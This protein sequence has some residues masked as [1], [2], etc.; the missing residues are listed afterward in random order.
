MTVRRARGVLAAAAIAYF[1]TVRVLGWSGERLGVT[2][3]REVEPVLVV[4]LLGL[5]TDYAVFFLSGMRSALATGLPKR[6]AMR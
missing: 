4:L 2:V 5:V 3:P 1:V 6:A